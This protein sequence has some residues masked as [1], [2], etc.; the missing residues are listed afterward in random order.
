MIA[1]R[2][3]FYEFHAK[4]V[5][6]RPGQP[7]DTRVGIEIGP[8][9][10]QEAALQQ[11]RTGRDV[12]TLASEDA[13]RLA[14]Q[15]SPGRPVQE[16]PHRP[17]QSSPTGRMDVYFPHYHPGGDHA[18]FGHIFFGHRGERYAAAH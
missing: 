11:V 13:Y 17:P 3:S 18:S 7:L 6:S 15:V 16:A 14:V 5:I 2:G 4:R 10:S 1:I 12:Y 9:I 8:H